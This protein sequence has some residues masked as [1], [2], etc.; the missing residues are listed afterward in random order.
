M[1]R[2]AAPAPLPSTAPYRNLILAGEMGVGKRALA[3]RVAAHFHAPLRDIDA[4]IEAAAGMPPPE[5]RALF[6]EAR[7]TNLETDVCREL[8]LQRGA[9]IAVS[10]SAM[11]NEGNRRRLQEIG[12]VLVLTTALNETLR[13]LHHQQGERFRDPRNRAVEIARLKR[14]WKVR[15]LSGFAQLDTTR[16]TFDQVAGQVIAFWQATPE[17]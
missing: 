9:V 14:E 4:E 10:A 11:L 6:G 13:R 7:L 3:E 16:L 1:H 2:P 15:A 17:V 12:V 8:T 5:V